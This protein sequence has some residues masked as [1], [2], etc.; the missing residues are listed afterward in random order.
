MFFSNNLFTR[1]AK[2]Y[3][4]S[5]FSGNQFSVLSEEKIS[6]S[7]ESKLG[8]EDEQISATE[9]KKSKKYYKPQLFDV[10][11]MGMAT[12]LT[13]TYYGWNYGLTAGFGSYLIAQVIQGLSYIVLVF[14]LAEIISSTSFS[15][16]AYGMARVMLGFYPG[17]LM[18]MFELTEYITY[19]GAA[20]QYV[21]AFLCTKLDWDMSYQSLVAFV[22][23]VILTLLLL[24]SDRIFWS[25]NAL[26]GVYC[27]FGI[28]FYCFGSLPYTNFMQNASMHN[29]HSPSAP[30][31]WFAGGMTV[32]L[33]VLPL[34]TWAFGGIEA[35]AL[36]TD[37]IHEPRR[38]LSRG[39]AIGVLSLFVLIIFTVFVTASLAPG[40]QSSS[41]DDD[42]GSLV[43]NMIFMKFGFDRMGI[44]GDFAEW[45]MLP[46][47]VSMAFGFMLPSAKLFHAMSCSK[48]IPQRLGGNNLQI[49]YMYTVPLS[50]GSCLLAIYYPK[51]NLSN[52]PV[53]FSSLTFLS[54]LYAYYQMQNDFVTLER[55]F[56]SPFGT[57]SVLLAAGVFLLTIVSLLGFQ[58]DDNFTLYFMICYIAL[59]SAY[60]FFY[61]KDRQIFSDA[62]Q[63]TLLTL[64]VLKMNKKRR[65]SQRARSHYSVSLTRTRVSA[66]KSSDADT[67]SGHLTQ[68]EIRS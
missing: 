64:H 67:K 6:E 51:F 59:L 41:Y 13:G 8:D 4:T 63:K 20:Y 38:N 45:L 52:V 18:A 25:I 7:H 19:A 12:V 28:L 34:T 21:A 33:Q 65:S 48:L 40:V 10:W 1:D 24:E 31:N 54:D 53:L 26:F 30:S 37:M 50:L 42:Y 36:V 14:A 47:Q 39:L 3:P 68:H 16:G 55:S 2:V 22:L 9:R 11:A 66:R 61:A 5:T 17:F 15:G 60:Y 43:N 56:K 46:A 29:D 44:G 58:Q 27:V 57:I 49:C 35:G 23:C 32:F 62:E